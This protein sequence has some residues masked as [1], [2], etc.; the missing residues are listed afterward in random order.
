MRLRLCFR[1]CEKDDARGDDAD[2]RV[3][4]EEGGVRVGDE[5]PRDWWRD[6]NRKIKHHA[7]DAIAFGA[8]LFGEQICHHRFMRGTSDLSQRADDHC[9]CGEDRQRGGKSHTKRA[10]RRQQ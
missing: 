6:D 9:H 7:D 2:D 5:Q 1:Q 3:H 4:D 10:E 8:F